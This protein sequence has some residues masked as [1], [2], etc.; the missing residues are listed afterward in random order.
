MKKIKV[1]EFRKK[2][3][4]IEV[5]V[6]IVDIDQYIIFLRANGNDV[7]ADISREQGVDGYRVSKDGIKKLF[8]VNVKGD[9]LLSNVNAPKVKEKAKALLKEYREKMLEKARK[10]L[11]DETEIKLIMDTSY[12]FITVEDVKYADELDEF[13]K[14][15]KLIKETMKTDDIEKVLDR[16]HDEI[17]MG[18]YSI[19][20]T[21]HMIYAE[22]KKIIKVAEQKKVEIE[23]RKQKHKTQKQKEIEEKFKQAR[24]IGE[25]VELERWSAGCDDPTADCDF[26]I[27]VKYAMPDGSTKTERYHTY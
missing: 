27:I 19:T 9:V 6:K 21:Y 4:T 12:S 15:V 2:G 3:K 23:Q 17:D 24:E 22:L 25:K 1:D 26:D 10:Q 5:F 14:G 11:T 18:D 8:N 20:Y 7:Y 16:K 13:K